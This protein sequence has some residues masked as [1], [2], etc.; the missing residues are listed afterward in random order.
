[1][2]L[3]RNQIIGTA[4]ELIERDGVAALSMPGLAS[5]LGCGIV[6]LYDRVPSKAAL[7]ER[8]AAAVMGEIELAVR[9][10]RQPA[11]NDRVR[12]QARAL[13]DVGR[14]YPR[15]TVLATARPAAS[16]APQTAGEHALGALCDA[17]F[18]GPDSARIASTFFAY[19]LGAVLRDACQAP[20]LPGERNDEDFEFGLD[21]LLRATAELLP[22][23][24][25]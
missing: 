12:A 25:S 2:R 9:R 5:E 20:G 22:A 24:A 23:Q 16:G 19:V 3:T 10:A 18:G 21:L 7:L 8:V 6:P 4:I 11:W 17:G 15:C 1:M 13:R 14:A